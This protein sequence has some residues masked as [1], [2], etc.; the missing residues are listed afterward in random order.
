MA[1]GPE[2]GSF[3]CDGGP[4][5]QWYIDMDAITYVH[6]TSMCLA[7]SSFPSGNPALVRCVRVLVG[8]LNVVQVVLNQFGNNE[9]TFFGEDLPDQCAGVCTLA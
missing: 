6:D 3:P 8:V 9:I 4:S 1:Q 5:Q 2:V 7:E